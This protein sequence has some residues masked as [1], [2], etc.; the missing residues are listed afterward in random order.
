MAKK[1]KGREVNEQKVV[2]IDLGGTSMFAAVVDDR[3]GQILG[4]AKRKTHAE[5]GAIVVVERIVQTVH[6]AIKNAELAK[7]DILG[8]GIGIP[9]PLHP[10]TGIVVNCPNMGPTWNDFALADT[11]SALLALP[12]T[13]D[14]D[15]N[16]GAVGEHT[17]GAGRNTQDMLAIFV[18]TGIGG[19]LIIDGQLH[20]GARDSAGEI[21]HMVLLPDGPM[22]G[23]G[24]RGHAEALASRTAIERDIRTALAEGKESLVLGLMK[25]G[26]QGIMSAGIIGQAYDSGDEVTRVAVAGAQYYLGLLLANCVN[27]LDPEAIIVGG[28]VLERMGDAYL[29]PARQVAVQHYV[30]KSDLD[31]VRIVRAELGDYSGAMGAAVLARRRLG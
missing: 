31:R 22:C 21:G 1:G 15:V 26:E 5:L 25:D 3:E 14:N 29:E 6:K 30:N 10:D 27:L 11:L 12:V 18:G 24:C 17:Y 4:Q 7:S 20:G 13:I 19:G 8:V 28:G 9:G 2:G 16:V 23:C